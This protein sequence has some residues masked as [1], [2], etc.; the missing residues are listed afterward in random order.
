V[1]TTEASFWAFI[2]GVVL[3]TK[4]AVRNATADKRDVTR[5]QPLGRSDDSLT[6]GRGPATETMERDGTSRRP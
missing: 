2:E 6:P 1:E 3:N 4:L 5:T